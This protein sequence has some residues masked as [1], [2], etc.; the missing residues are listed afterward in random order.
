VNLP[1]RQQLQLQLNVFNA[2][3]INSVTSIT[4]QSGP[5]Y[6]LA[7]AI[8]LPRIVAFTAHYIF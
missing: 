1:S 5:S 2:T 8:V 7:T 3:N 4:Q 6:G